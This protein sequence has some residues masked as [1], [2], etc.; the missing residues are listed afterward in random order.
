MT[1]TARTRNRNWKKVFLD[2]LEDTASVTVACRRAEV[3]RKTAYQTRQRDAE[4]AAQWEEALHLGVYTLEDEAIRRARDGVTK[5]VYQQGR[6]VGAVQEYSD[7]LLMFLLKAHLPER[8]RENL[9]LTSGGKPL[10][11]NLSFGDHDDRD[12][13]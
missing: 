4:F 9:D 7:T 2:A 10:T 1:S 6:E 11:F 8:Y 13:D 12:G 5:P 3:S